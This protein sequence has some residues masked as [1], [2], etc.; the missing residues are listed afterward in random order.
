MDTEEQSVDQ[1]QATDSLSPYI[2]D[3]LRRQKME[4]EQRRILQQIVDEISPP[5]VYAPTL[6]RRIANLKWDRRRK[7]RQ[8]RHDAKR[9]ALKAGATIGAPINRQDIILRDKSICYLCGKTCEPNEIHLD[10][11]IPL[12]KG[13]EHSATNLRVACAPCNIRKSDS[14]L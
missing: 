10:H 9:R 6:D 3:S 5:S 14:V 7:R 13:G 4:A 8:Q 11:V 12:S 2:A 1:D